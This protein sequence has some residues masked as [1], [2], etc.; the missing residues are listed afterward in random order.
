MDGIED[1]SANIKHRYQWFVVV[2]LT[3]LLII[4]NQSI[5][6]S[7]KF[8]IITE[9]NVHIY[10]EKIVL[11]DNGDVCACVWKFVTESLRMLLYVHLHLSCTFFV[12]FYA[13]SNTYN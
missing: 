6:Y 13:L 5:Q 4:C 11:V 12:D 10:R 7:I 9:T 8:D 2:V 3:Y 1:L